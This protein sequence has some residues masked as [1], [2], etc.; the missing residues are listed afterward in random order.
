M[1]RAPFLSAPGLPQCL[2]GLTIT[3]A[4]HPAQVRTV[5][6][7][8]FQRDLRNGPLARDDQVMGERQAHVEK[9]R[10]R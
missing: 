7:P 10:L 4:E 8:A 2:R 5:A 6:E 1:L 3:A 9:R